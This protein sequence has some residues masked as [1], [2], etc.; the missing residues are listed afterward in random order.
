MSKGPS[1]S[2]S[3]ISEVLE[4]FSADRITQITILP[5][6]EL[7]SECLAIEDTDDQLQNVLA[8]SPI[9]ARF[10]PLIHRVAQVL[11]QVDLPVIHRK[12]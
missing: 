3:P 1:R 2:L 7:C 9:A 5:A 8:R 10:D 6:D 12:S 4:G 11:R